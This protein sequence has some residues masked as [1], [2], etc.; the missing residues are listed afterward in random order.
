MNNAKFTIGDKVHLNVTGTIVKA[1]RSSFSD[2]VYY[3]LVVGKSIVCGIDEPL[4][5][6]EEKG[7]TS[8]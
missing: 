7:E 8:V 6:A 3:N 4:L 5:I 2:N 1:E